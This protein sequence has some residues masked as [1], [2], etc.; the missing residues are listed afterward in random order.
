MDTS[1]GILVKRVKPGKD[2]KHVL[3]VSEDDAYDPFELSCSNIHSLAL[4]VGIIRSMI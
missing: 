1:Q 4:V 3:I 2:K